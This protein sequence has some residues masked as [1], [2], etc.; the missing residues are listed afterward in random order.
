MDS[1]G[2]SPALSLPDHRICHWC[3]KWSIYSARFDRSSR[4]TESPRTLWCFGFIIGLPWQCCWPVVSP[5]PAKV[6]P[7]RRYI[8]KQAVPWTRPCWRP[9]VGFTPR[10]AW[11]ARSTWAW[12]RPC[13][14]PGCRTA[15]ATGCTV[16]RPTRWSSSTNTISGLSSSCYCK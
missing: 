4:C 16:M 15:R 3:S 14:I 1:K 5:W 11:C 13:P 2:P 7:A 8:A 6:S 9:S 10:I 12:A